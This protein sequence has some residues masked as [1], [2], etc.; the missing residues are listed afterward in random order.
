MTTSELRLSEAVP[1]GTAFLQELCRNN[2]IPALF[3]KGPAATILGFR[4]GQPSTD[5]DVLV[6]KKDKDKAVA[7]LGTMGWNL[8]GEGWEEFYSSHSVTLFH[9]QWPCDIDIHYRFPG[10]SSTAHA[11]DVLYS[12]RQSVPLGGRDIDV[13]GPLGSVCFQALHALRNPWIS[14]QKFN[15]T[16]LVNEAPA[17]AF[18]SLLAFSQEIDALA[19]MKPYFTAVYTMPDSF[20]WPRPSREWLARTT[21]KT[22]GSIRLMELIDAPWHEKIQ[23]LKRQFTPSSGTTLEFQ[24]PISGTSSLLDR[25]KDCLV[26]IT[27]FTR[28][29][30]QYLCNRR[31]STK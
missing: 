3:L 20:A 28:E 7:L 17:P 25:L 2:G 15:F 14:S 5:I 31:T 4:P 30:V 19:A 29:T 13:P 27:S 9:S 21:A 12:E 1:L 10:M 8:R 16:F 6:R 22:R 11:F 26:T 18:D 24:T 23:I